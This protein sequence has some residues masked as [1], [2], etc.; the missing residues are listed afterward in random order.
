[1][2]ENRGVRQVW[3]LPEEHRRTSAEARKSLELSGKP[4]AWNVARPVGDG[5]QIH[6]LHQALVFEAAPG[7]SF[8]P[9]SLTFGRGTLGSG[10]SLTSSQAKS[11]KT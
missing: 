9:P 10:L 8:W 7:A 2:L 1:M 6:G 4:D 3:R 5:V 11:E